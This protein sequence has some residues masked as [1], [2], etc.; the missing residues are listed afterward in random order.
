MEGTTFEP[1]VHGGTINVSKNGQDAG[2]LPRYRTFEFASLQR[3]VSNELLRAVGF[4]GAR[5]DSRSPLRSQGLD[6]EVQGG[7]LCKMQAECNLFALTYGSTRD[8]TVLTSAKYRDPLNLDQ[9]LRTCETS[10]GN[11]RTCWKIITEDLLS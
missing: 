6:Y 2:F 11:Q 9:H 8:L 10:D 5:R 3:R 4:D 1:S 7:N